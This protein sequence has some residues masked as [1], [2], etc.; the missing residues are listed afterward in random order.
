M[1]ELEAN[2]ERVA[3]RAEQDRRLQERATA[4]RQTAAPLLEELERATPIL[5]HW[6]PRSRTRG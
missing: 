1:A 3:Q 4:F 2:P 5:L 6:L